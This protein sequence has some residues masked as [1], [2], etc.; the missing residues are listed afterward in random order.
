[1]PCFLTEGAFEIVINRSVFVGPVNALPQFAEK[2]WAALQSCSAARVPCYE[3][4]SLGLVY[5]RESEHG[6]ASKLLCMSR[7]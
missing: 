2:Q 7:R 3:A 4:A 6:L 1:M 5:R